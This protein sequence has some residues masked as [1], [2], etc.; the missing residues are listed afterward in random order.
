MDISIF[1]DPNYDFTNDLHKRNYSNTNFSD[2][3]CGGAALL[4]FNAFIP[5]R[6]R[7]DHMDGVARMMQRG[8]SW[9]K[10]INIVLERDIKQMLNEFSGRLKLVDCNYELNQDERLIAY[11]IFLD[12]ELYNIGISKYSSIDDLCEFIE[13]D[14]HFKFKDYNDKSWYQKL[15]FTEDGIVKTTV[16][17]WR[18][19]SIYYN[20]RTVFFCLKI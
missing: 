18:N 15:G 3:N 2:Y 8:Y 14:F 12:K 6:D 9:D 10:T 1:T 4:T 13:S 11:R 19:G 16:N 7:S 5:Y 17:N 20:S